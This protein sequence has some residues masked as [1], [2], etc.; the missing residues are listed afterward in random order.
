MWNNGCSLAPGVEQRR[1]ST[2]GHNMGER[3]DD[4]NT[5]SAR[6]NICYV[7]QEEYNVSSSRMIKI[8]GPDSFLAQHSASGHQERSYRQRAATQDVAITENRERGSY[9]Q[10][11]EQVWGQGMV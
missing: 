7:S 4:L 5:T 8:W 9:G 2:M 6:D 10:T 1:V 3:L 11:I